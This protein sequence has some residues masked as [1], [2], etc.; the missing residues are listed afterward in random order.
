[1]K[2]DPLRAALEPRN[3][4]LLVGAYIDREAGKLTE[5]GLPVTTETLADAYNQDVFTR[6]KD[7]HTEYVSPD[8]P[9]RK[10]LG[11]EWKPVRM[12]DLN[13]NNLSQVLSTSRHVEHINQ[14]QAWIES[15]RPEFKN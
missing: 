12:A 2:D 7:G 10:T 8:L 11:P 1:M 4:A 13:E 3:A 15:H 5:R 14:Q 9:G 6:T